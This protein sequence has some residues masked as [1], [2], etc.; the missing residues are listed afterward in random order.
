ML[1]GM[2]ETTIRALNDLNRRFYERFAEPFDATRGSAWAGW[3]RLLPYLQ[4]GV[5]VLDVGCGNGRFGVFLAE[6]LGDSAFSYH[7]LDNNTALLERA[8]NALVNLPYSTLEVCDLV[9]DPLP[10]ATYGCVALFG[11]LHHIPG[12]ERRLAFLRTLAERVS[13]GGNLVITTWRFYDYPRFRDRI[14]PW[15]DGL[16]VEAGDYLLDWQHD[17]STPRYCHYVDDSEHGR[18]IAATGL[19]VIDDF[20]ADG[21]DGAVNRYTVLQRNFSSS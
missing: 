20:R 10:A 13:P 11:V 8:R 14:I 16:S 1:S 9:V 19:T 18:L 2:D 6:T 5:S 15:G 3:S 17:G 7:G 21:F 12:Q 4:P